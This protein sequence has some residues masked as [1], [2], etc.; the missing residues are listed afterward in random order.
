MGVI[1]LQFLDNQNLTKLNLD[2]SEVFEFEGLE[3]NI[4]PNSNINV[5]A[6]K[7]D[8]TE[9]KFSTLLRIDTQIEAEYYYNGGLLPYVLRKMVKESS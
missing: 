3:S 7:D 2:G 1:P 8:G 5:T 9:I 4:I 6:R